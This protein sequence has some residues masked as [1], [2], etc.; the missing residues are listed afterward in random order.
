MMTSKSNIIDLGDL[1]TSL[2]TT[3]T[4][5]YPKT[6]IGEWYYKLGNL[7][8]SGF[9]GRENIAE[10]IGSK[11]AKSLGVKTVE[12]NLC[13]V[14]VTING[15]KYKTI[16]VKSKHMDD[17]H[18]F[19]KVVDLTRNV[20]KSLYEV[21][22]INDISA[23]VA[24]DGI[25]GQTDRHINNIAL[26]SYKNLILFDY[27]RSLLFDTDEELLYRWEDYNFV[28]Y[29]NY[30]DFG[31]NIKSILPN[32]IYICLTNID[33]QNIVQDTESEYNNLINKDGYKI[34]KKYFNELS[35]ML[36]EDIELYEQEWN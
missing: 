30:K 2:P 15:K 11:I 6:Q 18:T 24:I 7:T 14:I 20:Y 19:G 34:T 32:L 3:S 8:V 12:Y 17:F 23:M 29:T 33:V 9:V 16:A 22:S 5:Q 13:D 4:G 27:G 21:F 26:D 36:K 31:M 25:T 1:S 28:L 10:V 35:K